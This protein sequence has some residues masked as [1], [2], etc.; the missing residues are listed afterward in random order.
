MAALAGSLAGNTCSLPMDVVKSRI[1]N[2]PVPKAGES[3]LYTGMLDCARKSV[4]AEGPMVLWK[5]FTPAFVKL[6]PYTVLSLGLLE[7][8]TFAMTGKSAL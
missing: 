1:Q 8:I 6:A 3:P 4:A 5:G 2:M 7:R